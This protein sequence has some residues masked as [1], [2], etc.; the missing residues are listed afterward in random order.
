MA[1]L[2]FKSAKE[3]EEKINEYFESLGGEI[4][5]DSEGE[6]V[7]YKGRIVYKTEP[8]PPTVCGL[9]LYIG[10]KSRQSLLNYQKRSKA[11]EDVIARAKLRIEAYT[12]G[13]LFDRD[14]SRGAQ[15]SLENNFGWK[16]DSQSENGDGN[17]L[18]EA[19]AKSAKELND[20][21]I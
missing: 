4:L 1:Y 2:K 3:M 12:E 15:F 8:I 13:R 18:M 14:G 20:L 5:A 16:R 19:I 21:E 9:A 6:P 10:L 7:I 17:N 11:Y